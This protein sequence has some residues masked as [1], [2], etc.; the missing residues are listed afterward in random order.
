M[1]SI[2]LAILGGFDLSLALHDLVQF[3]NLA[4]AMGWI[5]VETSVGP[6][7]ASSVGIAAALM[8]AGV[9]LV[10]TGAVLALRGGYRSSLAI[11]RRVGR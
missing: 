5:R 2:A 7:E 10:G 8:L 1:R 11:P 6:V 4:V 3:K 9:L